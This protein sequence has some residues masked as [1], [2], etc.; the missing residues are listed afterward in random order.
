M[1][2]AT[3]GSGLHVAPVVQCANAV[4]LSMAICHLGILRMHLVGDSLAGHDYGSESV[5][6]ICDLADSCSVT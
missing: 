1:S 3:G 4:V 6:Q 5:M 2:M